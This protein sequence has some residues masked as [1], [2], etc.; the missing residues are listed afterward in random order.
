MMLHTFKKGIRAL[1]IAE[2][3]TRDTSSKSVL[4]GVVMR[5]DFLVDGFSFSYVTIG[6]LDATDAV[7]NLY[8]KLN[9]RDISVLF[10]NGCIISW[11][12]IMDLNRI[13]SELKIPLVSLTYRESLGL[14]DH[15]RNIFPQDYDKRIEIY[16]RNGEREKIK[17]KTG[18]EVFVRYLGMGKPTCRQILNRFTI[19]GKIPEPVKVARILAKSINMFLTNSHSLKLFNTISS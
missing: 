13:Y 6:G 14:N 9:R 2:S 8:R 3:F 4:A 10:I 16:R 18:Y 5:G 19:S 12:N 1:G 7:L 17:L 11:Y 15:F